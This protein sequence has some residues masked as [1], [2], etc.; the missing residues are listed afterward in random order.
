MAC[1]TVY[2][3][4]HIK[5]IEFEPL[6]G[7][8][9]REVKRR[10]CKASPGSISLVFQDSALEDDWRVEEL[11][12]DV[13]LHME[14]ANA[15]EGGR[16]LA[17]TPVRTLEMPNIKFDDLPDEYCLAAELCE[18]PG[19]RVLR[20]ERKEPGSLEIKL[21][22]EALCEFE[23][24]PVEVSE[25]IAHGPECTAGAIVAAHDE[26][27]AAQPPA[28]IQ[29]GAV[30]DG[31]SADANANVFSLNGRCY[32]IT[33]RRKRITLRY[34]VQR[35]EEFFTPALIF[36]CLMLMFIMHTNNIFFLV[37]IL[38]LRLMRLCSKVFHDNKTWLYFGHHKASFMFFA[39]MFFLDHTSFFPGSTKATSDG[40]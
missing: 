24:K 27:A 23:S 37:V 32:R 35:L 20:D 2:T 29:E 1:V 8:T 18:L 25:P 14:D 17:E 10:L 36:Q 7:E 4:D 6:E 3:R 39:S 31:S 34:M 11:G 12:E 13:V 38:S 5:Q 30:A 16:C 22:P 33:S 15:A 21:V 28:L 40:Y 26:E 9:V 19:E